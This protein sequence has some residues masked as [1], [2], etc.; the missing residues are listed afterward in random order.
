MTP[1]PSVIRA[2]G[3]LPSPRAIS[4][5]MATMEEEIAKAPPSKSDACHD[6]PNALPQRK[7][8]TIVAGI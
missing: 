3:L 4:N 5:L 7:P 8:T 1:M 6:Q 2:C